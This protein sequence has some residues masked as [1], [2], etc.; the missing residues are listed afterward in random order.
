MRAQRIRQACACWACDKVRTFL[1]TSNSTKSQNLHE[2]PD[3]LF[4]L[5]QAPPT[6]NVWLAR[7][8]VAMLPLSLQS[9]ANKLIHSILIFFAITVTECTVF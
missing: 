7:L 4:P 3:V 2:L 1:N 9:Y 5:L 8:L 6:K